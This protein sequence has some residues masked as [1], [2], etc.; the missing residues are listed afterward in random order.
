MLPSRSAGVKVSTSRRFYPHYTGVEFPRSIEL[1]TIRQWSSVRQIDSRFD[2]F[3]LAPHL[4]V[5]SQ[6][7]Y[8]TPIRFALTANLLGGHIATVL[9]RQLPPCLSCD[10]CH[11]EVF[12][13][14]S[15]EIFPK[16]DLTRL[17]TFLDINNALIA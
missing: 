6:R 9:S 2:G 3:R 7:S 4:F 5:L 13:G 11:L 8:G 12:A 10:K 1:H 16:N 15:I 17:T 14:S